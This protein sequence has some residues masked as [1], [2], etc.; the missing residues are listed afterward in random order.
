MTDTVIFHRMSSF[1]SALQNRICDALETIDRTGSFKHTRWSRPEGGGGDTRVL[2]N[3]S[4]FEKAAVNT[5]NVFG[6]LS[7]TLSEHLKGT[8]TSFR[9]TGI[10]LILH[11]RSPMVPTVHANFR[12]I[13]R[14]DTGWYGGGA[15][16]TPSYLFS[17]DCTHFHTIWR[18]I[19]AKH[20]EITD[21]DRW[22][23]WC[24]EY[25]YSSH[26]K[27]HRGIGGIFYDHLMVDDEAGM[28]FTEDAGNAFLASYLPIVERRMHE[29]YTAAQRDFQLFHR[30]RY[31]EFNL[32]HD[33]GTRFGFQSKGNSESILVSMPPLAR[34]TY[35][36]TPEPNSRE[37]ET[38]KILQTPRDWV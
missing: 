13:E 22:K 12:R 36:Y 6:P 35:D 27:E 7:E 26:R 28:A 11:P 29:P 15:D 14:G 1:V 19:C 8:G 16:L 38:M 17:E 34:W 25:F 21:Y 24:D 31:V 10:S 2:E 3:G 37:S 33:R 18:D 5:S 32:I 9:A 4:I 30:G 23:K 20:P